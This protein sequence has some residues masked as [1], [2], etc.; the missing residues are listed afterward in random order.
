VV[1]SAAAV[2]IDSISDYLNRRANSLYDYS[3]DVAGVRDPVVH[4]GD[5]V[6]VD[7]AQEVIG[8]SLEGI[9]RAY[10]V[11]AMSF[12]PDNHVVND[13]IDGVPVTV[14]Y[15]DLTQCVR[16]F[17]AAEPRGRALDVG[18]AGLRR[19]KLV[20]RIEGR[21]YIQ[22]DRQIALKEL[23][24]KRTTWK[25]WKAAHPHSGVYLGQE[26]DQLFSNPFAISAARRDA[27]YRRFVESSGMPLPNA[28]DRSAGDAD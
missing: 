12:V 17:S 19:G 1:A 3:F 25:E 24:F 5:D 7:P 20:L 16:V 22:D 11:R 10:S 26:T 13:L 23:S 6:S 28:L 14:T 18:I 4:S 27:G 2:A 15:C 21:E 9:D 8:I